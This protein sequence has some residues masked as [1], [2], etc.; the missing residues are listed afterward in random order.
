MDLGMSA[1]NHCG[2]L[3]K[4]VDKFW[5][6]TIE[7]QLNN[8]IL[9]TSEIDDKVHHFIHQLLLS[10]EDDPIMRKQAHYKTHMV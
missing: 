1:L 4:Y 7:K 10:G 9:S 2:H 5:K 8:K 6:Y 3:D